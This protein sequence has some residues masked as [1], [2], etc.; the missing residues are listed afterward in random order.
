ML[1][2]DGVDDYVEVPAV[3]TDGLSTFSASFWVNT[4]ESGSNGTYHRN[5]TLFGM[6]RGGGSQDWNIGQ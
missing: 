3:V 4:T 2:V 6:R 1:N 5:P